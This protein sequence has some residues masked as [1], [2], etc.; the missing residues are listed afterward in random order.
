VYAVVVRE[1][2]S[3]FDLQRRQDAPDLRLEVSSVSD[4]RSAPTLNMDVLACDLT[5]QGR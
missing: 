1:I 4:D 3:S 2:T 5:P